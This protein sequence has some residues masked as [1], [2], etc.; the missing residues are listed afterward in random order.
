V[1]LF[2]VQYLPGVGTGQSEVSYSDFLIQARRGNI[3]EVTIVRGEA[4]GE[5]RHA[6]SVGSPRPTEQKRFRVYLPAED[7]QL[8][9]EILA[10][11]STVVVKSKQA[12]N[13]WLNVLL[14]WSIPLLIVIVIWVFFLRQMQSGGSAALK[15]GKS[16]ARIL[17]ENQI[18]VNFRD[19]AGADEAKEELQEIIEFLRDPKKF[20]VLGGR[21]PKGAL[22]L[23]PPGTGKTLLAKAV[24]GEAGVPFFSMSGSDFVEMF[25]GVGASVTGDTPVLVRRDGRVELTEIGA[26]V[27]AYYA[28][29][30]GGYIVAAKGL[31]TLGYA[32]K[33]SK[34]RGSSKTL[35][36]G[37]AWTPVRQV[38]RHCVDEIYEI[39]YLGG[40][41]RTTG[42]HSVFIRTRDGI[43]AVPARSLQPGDILVRLPFKV[44][45]E[46]SPGRGTPH[47]IR[48]HRLP[49]ETALHL[50][51][52]EPEPEAE[53]SHAFA[54]SSRGQAPQHEIGAA[55]GVSQMTI[56]N[57]QRG[58][59]LPRPL[60]RLRAAA[61]LP[62]SVPVTPDLMRM[63]GY[64]AAEGRD[65]GCLQF[66]FGA[67]E[68]DLHQDV[69]ATMSQ[70]FGVTPRLDETQD[71]TLRITYHHAPLGRFFARHCG[72]GSGSK[73]LPAFAWE[74]PRAHFEG[75]LAG[76]SRGDGYVTPDG[77]LSM[78]SISRRL[79]REL[80]WLCAL[81][82]IPSGVREMNL[83][84]GRTIKAKPL[85]AG[86]AWNLLVGKS[87]N[88]LQPTTGPHAMEKRA[89]VRRIERKAYQGFVYDLCGCDREAFFGGE[90]P[91]LLHNSRVRDLFEQGK[92][93]AP[94]II[95]ID[96]IDAVGR[97]RGAGLGG[98]H[99]EREQTLNQLLVEMDG[100]ESNEG[101]ILIAATNRP[102]VLDPAL[103]RPGRFDRQ[104]VVDQPDA[105]G[106]EGILKVHSR[107][108]PLAEDVVL[109]TLARGTP[110]FSGADLANM[111]NEGAL[112]A[113]RKGRKKITMHDLEEARDKV[114]MG[115]ERKSLILSEEEKRTTAYHEAGHA[116]VGWMIPEADPIHKVTIIPRGR[117]LGVTSMLPENDRHS[118]SRE[119]LNAMLTYML[120]GRAAEVL[121]FN[122]LTSGAS[123][124]IRRATGIARSMVC[125]LG[126]SDRLGPLKFGKKEEMIFLG[127]E[128]SQQRDYSER[129]AEIIDEEVQGLANGAY[130][131]A[132]GILQ[133]NLRKLH[134]VAQALLEREVL[135][136][137]ELGRIINGD[138]GNGDE[139]DDVTVAIASD[140]DPER[141]TSLSGGSAPE[142][143]TPPFE[144]TVVGT[145]AAATG[146]AVPAS[147]PDEA[148]AVGGPTTS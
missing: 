76:Y 128:I 34:F 73:H 21:I 95:F 69:V 139:T 7:P 77:K 82:G 2:L 108:K 130:D 93:N 54:L 140:A 20:Q 97:H 86:R 104:I 43:K 120:G 27:D 113:A 50:P 40:S 100:F 87:S 94:C 92:K 85:P 4:R 22:L 116:L 62:E 125:E 46:W 9:K 109:D 39:E 131:R 98:G 16:K 42:D 59:H 29:D 143:E 103:L 99:D 48:G 83:P 55:L 60:A 11:D 137:T 10:A 3:K 118:M 135:D 30:E 32:E 45:G 105:R 28:G 37:T 132:L 38:F 126:M 91:V 89:V 129:T 144:G 36:G 6:I 47:S 79:I 53:D 14:T 44:R 13:P 121:I 141:R 122:R 142:G 117:A 35:V 145:G 84:A 58:R 112:L 78:T 90:R 64:Y 15:F 134:A 63:L 56:S 24:A 81:H 75:F 61:G 5:F 17:N 124:D 101:V 18:K 146:N 114:M 66:V 57:W 19:V 147:T 111:M 115:P 8:A 136:R 65:N 148:P 70:I 127:K 123:D 71:H 88:P 25:V 26:L 31:E 74:L 52:C 72:N 106:R 12:N 23:G 51:L 133:A 110:G 68:T 138:E 80:S 49:S 102:D 96:E 33:D 1:A 41:I 107:N 67:H 119:Q